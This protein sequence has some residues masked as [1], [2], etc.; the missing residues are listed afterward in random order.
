VTTR[1]ERAVREYEHVA[2]LDRG[3]RVRKAKIVAV[4]VEEMHVGSEI[5][6]SAPLV[7]V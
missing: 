5:P 3:R 2:Q 7:G 6:S 4:G 1:A